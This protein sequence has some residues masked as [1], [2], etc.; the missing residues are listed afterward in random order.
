MEYRQTRAVPGA[1]AFAALYARAINVLECL[2][3]LLWTAGWISVRR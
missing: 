2:Y 1:V 3:T